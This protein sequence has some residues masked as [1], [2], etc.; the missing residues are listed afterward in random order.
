METGTPWRP[1]SRIAYERA[2]AILHEWLDVTG[3]IPRGV[4]WEWELE[5]VLKDA[6]ECGYQ[7]ALGI[8]E[9]LRS[10]IDEEMGR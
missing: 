10:E 8:H 7:A 2:R 4:S 6:V 9:P 5:S 1:E 3:A